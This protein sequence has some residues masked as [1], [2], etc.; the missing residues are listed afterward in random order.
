MSCI[1]PYGP[2][3]PLI[4]PHPPCSTPHCPLLDTI[5]LQKGQPPVATGLLSEPRRKHEGPAGIP[6]EQTGDPR[7]TREGPYCSTRRSKGGL[8]LFL[9]PR[10]CP[11]GDVFGILW[12][13]ERRPMKFPECSLKTYTSTCPLVRFGLGQENAPCGQTHQNITNNEVFR[14]FS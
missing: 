8:A 5:L 14:Q 11:A 9:S 2:V 6:K 3:G 4:A 12:S 1:S 10:R 13:I 7:G